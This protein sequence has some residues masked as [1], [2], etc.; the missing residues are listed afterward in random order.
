MVK[1]FFILLIIFLIALYFRI[2]DLSNIPAGLHGDEASIGYNAYSLLKTGHDQNGNFLPITIDQFGDYRPA[3]YH[4]L[5]I[6]FVALI[7]LNEI[8]VRLPAA[9]F[10]A[11]T[12]LALYLLLAELFG[13]KKIALLGGGLLAITPWH[14]TISRATSESVIASFFVILGTYIFLKGYKSKRHILSLLIIAF[15]F[16]LVSFLFYHSARIFV[17]LLLI[18]LIP[19]V[20]FSFKTIKRVKI[21]VIGLSIALL[22]GLLFIL[23]A[24]RGTARPINISVLNIPGGDKLIYQQIGEDGKQDPFITRFFHNKPDFYSRLFLSSYFQHF[25]GQFIFVTNGLP[26]RY[27]V[28][29]TGNLHLIYLPFLL[30]GFAMLLTEGVKDRKFVGL[31]PILW[32]FF[33]AVPAGLTYEDIPNIQRA[34]LML[35]GLIMLTAYGTYMFFSVIP[36]KAKVIT[37]V[38]CGIILLQN[39]LYFSHNYF[40][41]SKIDEPWYRSAAVKELMFAINDLS[42]QY[43]KIVMTT[44]GNNSFIHYLFYQKVDPKIFQELGSPREKDMLQFQNVVYTY[45]PCPLEG[46]TEREEQKSDISTVYV[47][48]SNCNNLPKN[49]RILRTI[50]HPDG[51]P[52]FKIV[53]LE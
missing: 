4:Y 52:A 19:I 28:P 25:S 6:P 41:H 39:S 24:G 18:F 5:A 2:Y 38:I 45:S 36:K 48:H 27:R 30:L 23:A 15:F 37:G 53:S 33:G 49:A 9:L 7:G 32:V 21:Y 46:S 34:S 12:V 47:N 20:F 8:A 31:L 11:A 22:L 44:N 17:P 26:I 16:Y 14:I 50:Y 42:K 35:P 10:G 51:M 1:S 3:G 29:W 13:N 43:K 40:L